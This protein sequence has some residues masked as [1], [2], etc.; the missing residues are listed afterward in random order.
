[1]L[2]I[3]TARPTRPLLILPLA[4]LVSSLALPLAW[5][6]PAQAQLL[7]GRAP[8]LPRPTV[9]TTAA[10]LSFDEIFAGL[11]APLTIKIGD[12]KGEW[13]L[14]KI[15]PRPELEG[16]AITVA[17]SR[18]ERLTSERLRDAI[19]A[20]NGQYLTQG[21][22]VAAGGE[23]FL[24]SYKMKFTEDDLQA[25]LEAEAR[26]NNRSLPLPPGELGSWLESYARARP[27]DLVLL[28]VKM[29]GEI[30]EIR[31]FDAAAQ[32]SALR[33]L[34]GSVADE[35]NRIL[36]ASTGTADGTPTTPSV[37]S[38]SS[39]S[40]NPP[41]G[42]PL[43]PAAPNPAAAPIITPS[44]ASPPT[45]K[46]STVIPPATVKPAPTANLASR[47]AASQKNLH[48]IGLAMLAYAQD[49]NSTLPPLHSPTVAKKVLTFYAGSDKIWKRADTGQVY[50][51]NPKLSGRKPSHL[52]NP[53]EFVAFYEAA[54]A[55]DGTRG[56]V[57]LDASVKRIPASQWARYK[58]ASKLP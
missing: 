2:R 25:A 13:R 52:S 16:G 18:E 6:A 9:P 41:G 56:V 47:N 49:H 11:N 39:P 4:S 57:F 42:T 24:V 3:S 35:A 26:Q 1:M 20:G 10:P 5:Q 40:I 23:L 17:N 55:G 27:L 31:A 51:P 22:T 46:T 45:P 36:S 7:S 30:S 28:N 54:P 19:G 14:V 53:D 33:S 12:L 43:L 34:I 37:V 15:K 48:L 29:L 58:K 44:V 8:V 32:G 21:Q 38:S 50:V